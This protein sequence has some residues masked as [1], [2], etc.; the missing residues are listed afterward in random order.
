L[1]DYTTLDSGNRDQ[2]NTGA[3]RDTQEGKPRYDLIPVQFLKELALHVQDEPDA[4]LDLVPVEPLLRLAAIYGRGSKKYGDNNYK[5]G[6]PL[7]RVY[8]S[9]LRHVFQ[10]AEGDRKEDHLMQAAWNL[11]T[12][13]WTET[14][15]LSG[16]LDRELDDMAVLKSELNPE[17]EGFREAIGKW[18]VTC[19]FE[20]DKPE[21][22]KESC[23]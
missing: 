16:Q 22:V 9:L 19:T 6:I 4:R 12:I 8:A 7:K 20:I 13:V 11:F 2:F 14:A 1:S 5:L 3:V 18:L 17:L 10:W 15:I 23:G 21:P